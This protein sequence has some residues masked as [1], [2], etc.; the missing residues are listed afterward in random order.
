[1]EFLNKIYFDN[2]LLSYIYVA[3]AIL[4]VLAFKRLLSKYVAVLL[5]KLINST[6]KQIDQSQFANLIIKPLG[7]FLVIT[8]ALFAID[9][10]N[11]PQEWNVAI[12]R[13]KLEL[14]LNKIG[15]IIFIY[16]FLKLFV[17]I[18]HFVSLILQQS[19]SVDKEHRQLI[20][21][22]RDFLKVIG[23][24]IGILSLLKVA[25]NVNI[26]AF[27]AGLGIA[28]AALALAAKESIENIIASFIIFLDKPFFTGDT[29]KVNA[30]SGKIERIGLRSTRIRTN[31]K[32]L[33]TVPNKQM[34]DSVVDNLSF[35]NFRRG[36][37][38]LEFSQD[39]TV[40]ILSNFK[41]CATL[42]LGDKKFPLSSFSV[43]INEYTKNGVTIT[44]EFFTT[45]IPLDDFNQ[46]KENIIIEI[47]KL[48]KELK[49]EL[50]TST[51]NL[52][53]VQ[54]D[55]GDDS[56]SKSNSII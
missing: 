40:E 48:V 51:S 21:F 53:I 13:I 31:E 3:C 17:S 35:R 15:I 56:P 37:I 4:F 52:T 22:F 33:I 25:F 20:I 24:I 12:F 43:M 39:S 36:E 34:V 46:I 27:V 42:I 7:N 2:T 26:G 6:W 9:K 1:M 54:N 23:Y 47:M 41:T 14:L 5:G 49:I 10:L 18:V 38:K 16:A 29:V 19:A 11:F 45:N 50:A 30:F 28:G 44:I 55:P 32:T 8:V